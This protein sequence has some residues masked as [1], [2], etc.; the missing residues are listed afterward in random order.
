MTSQ[1]LICLEA[2]AVLDQAMETTH[3]VLNQV[4]NI[5]SDDRAES[6]DRGGFAEV[7]ATFCER[8]YHTLGFLLYR[9]HAPPLPDL[10]GYAT[11]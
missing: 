4:A 3:S 7:F 10:G 11:M 9:R 1:S 8:L 5:I 6:T 2:F